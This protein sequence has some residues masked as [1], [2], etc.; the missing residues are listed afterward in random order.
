M[1][2]VDQQPYNLWISCPEVAARYGQAPGF[3]AVPL[4]EHEALIAAGEA[5]STDVGAMHFWEIGDC[6]HA[7]APEPKPAPPPS[8]TAAARRRI[9]ATAKDTGS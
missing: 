9:S 4:G 5:Q 8:P 6:S 2:D 1:P 3:V 7:V